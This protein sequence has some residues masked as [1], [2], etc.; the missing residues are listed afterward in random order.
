MRTQDLKSVNKIYGSKQMKDTLSNFRKNETLE[1]IVNEVDKVES[2]TPSVL[3][4]IL[5]KQEKTVTD[6]F[7]PQPRRNHRM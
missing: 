7:Y 2:T 5:T 3:E 1:Q 6:K 4:R